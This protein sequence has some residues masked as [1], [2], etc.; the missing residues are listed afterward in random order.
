MFDVWFGKVELTELIVYFSVLILIPIQL[1]LCF[2]ANN[3]ALRLLPIGI[4]SL[5]LVIF[6]CM[7]QLAPGW[8]GIGYAILAMF[9]GI[10]LVACS[11]SWGIWLAAKIIVN[12]C[13]Y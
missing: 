8:D 6:L 11:I 1:S 4:L 5:L 10:L 2:K 3:K 12:T 13:N 9:A 7:I